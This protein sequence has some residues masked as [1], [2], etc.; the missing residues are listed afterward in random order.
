[1][2]SAAQRR[3]DAS[4]SSTQPT[5]P[6]T[7]PEA[8]GPIDLGAGRDDFLYQA[9]VERVVGAELLPGQ[10]ITHGVAPAQLCR[11]AERTAPERHDPAADLQLPEPHVVGGDDDVG[12]QR[13]F[14]A[15]G[16]GN[17][18]DR[19][20]HRLGYLRLP[21]AE[22]VVVMATREGFGALGGH[23]GADLGEIETGGEVGA[24]GVHHAHPGIGFVG[25]AL[26]G[27]TE[28]FDGGEIERV[29]LLGSVD[30]NAKNVP[31]EVDCHPGSHDRQV[32]RGIR[33]RRHQEP[34]PVR[35]QRSGS[36]SFLPLTDFYYM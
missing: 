36:G 34:L 33:A 8:S 16:E 32:S 31:V 10:Q 20:H 26:V 12:G 6:D 27:G 13:E 3:A 11:T 25:E 28:L 23:G 2:T 4:S 1:M 17:A 24:V 19:Q 14:D 22:W 15:Q 21:D 5:A 9:Y 7:N 30:P 35:P 18:V 29:A